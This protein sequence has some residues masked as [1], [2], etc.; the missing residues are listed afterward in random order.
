MLSAANSASDCLPEVDHECV[1]AE[2]GGSIVEGGAA[3]VVAYDLRKLPAGA[4]V[5]AVKGANTILV[6][7]AGVLAVFEHGM[8]LAESGP[9]RQSPSGP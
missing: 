3:Q 7:V 2:R 1:R 8:V 9:C 5:A 4:A 6:T